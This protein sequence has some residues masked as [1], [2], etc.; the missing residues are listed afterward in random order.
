MAAADV[1][2]EITRLVAIT[3]YD[4]LALLAQIQGTVSV[5]CALGKE[6]EV[7][8]VSYF[9]GPVALYE[10]AAKNAVQWRFAR[11]HSGVVR[12]LL[13][14]HFRITERVVSAPQT[15]FWFER[16]NRVYVESDAICTEPGLC[17]GDRI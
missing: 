9:S 15:R 6:G 16:P 2:P 7:A 5:E 14:Y 10:S 11:G 4:R 8:H 3:R 13:H 12:V 17:P 1:T